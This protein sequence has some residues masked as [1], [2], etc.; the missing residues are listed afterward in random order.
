METAVLLHQF[1]TLSGL[2]Q[3]V[4]HSPQCV[5]VHAEAP[6]TATFHKAGPLL[7]AADEKCAD[8][9]SERKALFNACAG[10]QSPDHFNA[11]V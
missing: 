10:S 5:P 3:A 2:H 4:D 6:P 9:R 7:A 8:L 11:E 1:L